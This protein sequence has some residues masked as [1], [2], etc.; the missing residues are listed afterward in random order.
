VIHFPPAAA[1]AAST[2]NG[3]GG[4]ATNS[5]PLRILEHSRSPSKTSAEFTVADWPTKATT[6]F[7]RA[8][9]TANRQYWLM[10]R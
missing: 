6:A 10:E 7:N 4:V 5:A 9:S 1:E 8:I 2:M 3:A